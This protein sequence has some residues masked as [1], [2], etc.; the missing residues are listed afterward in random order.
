M[1]D[2]TR[3]WVRPF[4]GPAGA[5][6]MAL[7][8]AQAGHAGEIRCAEMLEGSGKVLERHWT[9]RGATTVQIDLPPAAGRDLL[10]RVAEKGVDVDVEFQDANGNVSGAQRQPRRA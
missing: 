8:T 5:I 1:Q 7:G 2:S 4:L 3:A 9:Q 10:V 6:L